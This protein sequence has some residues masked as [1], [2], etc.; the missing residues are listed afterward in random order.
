MALKMPF[1][2]RKKPVLNRDG[3]KLGACLTG[4]LMHVDNPPVRIAPLSIRFRTF[5]VFSLALIHG[6][7]GR[8]NPA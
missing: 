8:K 2:P 1:L 5:D 3:K 7:R 6:A 4:S